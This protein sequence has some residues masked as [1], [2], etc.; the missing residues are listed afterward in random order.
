MP[1]IF[2]VDEFS[3]DAGRFPRLV[4]LVLEGKETGGQ[5]RT[6]DKDE[7]GTDRDR[8]GRREPTADHVVARDLYRRAL[9]SRFVGAVANALR[10]GDDVVEDAALARELGRQIPSIRREE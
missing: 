5:W 4:R 3:E 7:D 2:A 6:K 1:E 8:A 9:L 10:G